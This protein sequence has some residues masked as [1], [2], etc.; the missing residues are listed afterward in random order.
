MNTRYFRLSLIILANLLILTASVS[1]QE[2]MFG[3]YQPV[4]LG[5]AWTYENVDD[6]FDTYTESVFELFE[7]EGNPAYKMGRAADDYIILYS[8]RGVISVY[9]VV[10]PGE[11][12]DPDHPGRVDRR[13]DLRR[14]LRDRDLRYHDDPGLG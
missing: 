7:Y 3:W 5:A 9:A 6:P 13:H 11:F 4:N 8:F 10:L 2:P 14:L 1:A 12:L